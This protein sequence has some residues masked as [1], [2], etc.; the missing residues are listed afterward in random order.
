MHGA[1]QLS[2]ARGERVMQRARWHARAVRLYAVI[3][4]TDI[5]ALLCRWR[6]Y[7]LSQRDAM[8]G[9]AKMPRMRMPRACVAHDAY[10][11]A[12]CFA[13]ALLPIATPCA[14]AA[15]PRRVSIVA[16]RMLIPY[17]ARSDIDITAQQIKM[18]RVDDLF[19][20]QYFCRCHRH[21]YAVDMTPHARYACNR[22]AR[23]YVASYYA[24]PICRAAALH[25]MRA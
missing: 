14:F 11:C 19:I 17:V 12:P 25:T 24:M 13:D 21:Y 3:T 10:A 20:C 7:A 22:D 2:C 23:H 15:V 18:L 9:D 6:V 1:P 5:R 16:A 8:R 4:F